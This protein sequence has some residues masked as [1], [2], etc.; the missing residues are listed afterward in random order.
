MKSEQGRGKGTE[1]RGGPAATHHEAQDLKESLI[2]LK[3]QVIYYT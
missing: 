1:A 2:S 3:L